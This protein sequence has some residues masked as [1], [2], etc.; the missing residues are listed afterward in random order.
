MIDYILIFI[1]NEKALKAL[2]GKV[3]ME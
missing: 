1:S 2:S 3:E